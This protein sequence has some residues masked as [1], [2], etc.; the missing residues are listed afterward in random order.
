MGNEIITH[1]TGSDND[2]I[3]NV[4]SALEEYSSFLDK[5]KTKN[6]LAELR[7]KY[8]TERTEIRMT[9]EEL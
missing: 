3:D 8:E 1:I 5:D 6:S 4:E 2:L 9:Q 7:S